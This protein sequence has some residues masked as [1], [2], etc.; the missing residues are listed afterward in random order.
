[1]EISAMASRMA[2]PRE[3]HLSV[4]FKMFS[5]LKSKHNEITVFGPTELE[6]GQTQFPTKDWSATPYVLCK[7]YVPLNAP[8]PRGI[9]FTMRAFVDSDH[10]RDYVTRRS[11]TG[12]I[13]FL[14]V[15]LSLFIQRNRLA[16]RHQAS[17][18]SS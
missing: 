8:P 4:L 12:F 9:G 18:P 5:F 15:L 13:V 10:A 6:I 16:A 3:G 17:V 7:E 11:R 2:L 14:T 1:M